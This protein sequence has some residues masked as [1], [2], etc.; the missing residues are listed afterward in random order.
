M[1]SVTEH[2][3]EVSLSSEHLGDDLPAPSTNWPISKILLL[4]CAMAGVQFAY[5]TMTAFV[6]PYL[7]AQLKFE[8]WQVTVTWFVG[9]IAGFFVQPIVGALSDNSRSPYGRRRP[10]IVLG[11]ILTSLSLLLL[12]FSTALGNLLSGA[13]SARVLAVLGVILLNVAANTMLSPVRAIV[14]DVVPLD[15]QEA[16]NSFSA[17]MFGLSF[18]TCN[19]IFYIAA[20]VYS[21]TP[22]SAAFLSLLETMTSVG[23]VVILF[24]LIPT[25]IVGV[26]EPFAARASNKVMV[27]EH[28]ADGVQQSKIVVF[29]ADLWSAARRMPPSIRRAC[30]VF[31][32]SWA[33]YFPFQVFTTNVF[34]LQTGTLIATA[35]AVANMLYSPIFSK[36]SVR[37][38]EKP[39]YLISQTISAIAM[40]FLGP[41]DESQGACIFL[42]VLIGVNYATMNI[43]PFSLIGKAKTDDAGAFAGLANCACVLAQALSNL[44]T[45]VVQAINPNGGDLQPIHVA[46]FYSFCA[47]ASTL[48]LAGGTQANYRRITSVL[49]VA[50]HAMEA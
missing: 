20:T 25:C 16:G 14:A 13:G 10:F 43:A 21:V 1:S 31:F 37:F 8:P 12:G 46:V 47:A 48:L 7:S 26:E 27:A 4:N 49:D 3:V 15:R 29:F 42:A 2:D 32:L 23:A 24:S 40:A 41:L 19:L 30:I 39:L 6:S 50:A 33:G 36:L 11:G 22:E 34:G 5:A 9:P 17:F 38:S 35:S 45:L 44:S 28:D 18:A